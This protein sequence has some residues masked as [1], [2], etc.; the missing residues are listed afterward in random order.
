M[1]YK[2]DDIIRFKNSE[3]RILNVIKNDNNTYLYLINNDKNY[4]DISIVKVE[5]GLN[6]YVYNSIMNDE[7]FNY[8]ASKIFLSYKKEL[9]ELLNEE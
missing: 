4:N 5:K 1:N 7:E 2:I 9:I 3:Y 6:G 8:I